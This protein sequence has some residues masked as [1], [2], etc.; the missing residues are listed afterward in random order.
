MMIVDDAP[1]IREV[2][3]HIMSSEGLEVV[4]EAKDGTEVLPA[5]RRAKPDVILMDIVMPAKSGIDATKEVLQEFPDIKVIACSTLDQQLMVNK[6]I[7]AGCV[8]YITKPFQKEKVVY[9]VRRAAEQS[10][11]EV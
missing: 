6:A 2:L 5:V 8:D 3:S 4:A 11:K 1:F 10:Q 9:S 7:E